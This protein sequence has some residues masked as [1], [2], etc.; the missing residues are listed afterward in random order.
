MVATL[1]VVLG[2][3]LSVAL[4]TLAE[5]KI[6]GAMQRRIGPNKVGYLGQL[7]PF[8]DGIK[9]IQKETVQPLESSHWLFLGAPFIAF[10]QALLNWLVQ[11]LDYGIALSELL[12]G[13]ILILVA[14]SELSI[15]GVIYSGWAA[16]SKYPFQGSLRSTAQQISY[17][18]SLSLI[19][20]TVIFTL[21]TV[22]LLDILAA[23]QPIGLFFALLP[24]AL[25]FIVAALAET[26]RPPFDQPE[27][28]SELVAGFFTEHSSI[29]F[30]LFFLGEYTN[31]IVISTLFF[32][33][34]F[35]VSAA[36]PMLFFFIWVRASLARL[37][38]DQLLVLGWAHILPFTIGY[39]LFLPPFLF[40]FDI[41]G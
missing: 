5:R 19:I 23:Q 26:S 28:E 7:Q 15:Y 8:A 33:L 1:I 20:L 11:P 31:I 22:N 9:L 14:I 40:T 3:V 39:I 32:I 24:M 38:F 6:M 36:L 25:L 30:A 29:S 34:F 41:L 18:V 13:G 4:M 37:R 21:G 10:Y 16:N 27:A 12:G 17:S 35:G 2:V